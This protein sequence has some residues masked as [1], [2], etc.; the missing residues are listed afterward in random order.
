MVM[1]NLIAVDEFDCSAETYWEKFMFEDAFFERLNLTIQMKKRE[2]LERKESDTELYRK[3]KN[4]PLMELPSLV[5]KVIGS[6]ASYLEES[7][8]NKTTKLYRYQ[9]TST[10]AGKRLDFQG[11]IAIDS[12]GDKKCRREIRANI[13]VNVMFIG[14]KIEEH[15]ARR[16]EDS[17]HLI[18]KFTREEITKLHIKG[19]AA[20]A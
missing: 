6:D 2:V 11:T 20:I 13:K 12:L 9:V 1:M 17:Y 5:S 16:L 10:A 15:L 18:T 3:I 19:V 4:T 8:F 7:W 14:G